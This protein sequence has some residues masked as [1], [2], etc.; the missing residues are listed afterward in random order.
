MWQDSTLREVAEA[1]HLVVVPALVTTSVA[2]QN[3]KLDMS[4]VFMGGS[5]SVVFKH[6]SR[7][8]VLVVPRK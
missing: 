2:V 5:S 8:V 1:L 3:S 7:Q 4:A 6:V